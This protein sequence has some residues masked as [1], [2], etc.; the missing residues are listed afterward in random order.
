MTTTNTLKEM[1][2]RY[3]HNLDFYVTLYDHLPYKRD[4]SYCNG[5]IPV[6]SGRIIKYYLCNNQEE[7]YVIQNH[8]DRT[9]ALLQKLRMEQAQQIHQEEAMIEEDSSEDEISQDQIDSLL[10]DV[11]MDSDVNSDIDT[12][13]D[14]SQETELNQE[15][16]S[17]FIDIEDW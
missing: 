6:Q 5:K 17:S 14:D 2:V 12:I 10:S 4:S 13:S 7:S 3:D 16:T 11:E 9:E 15:S 8:D 1:L